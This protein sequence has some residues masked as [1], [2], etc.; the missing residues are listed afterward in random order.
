LEQTAKEQTPIL[1]NLTSMTQQTLDNTKIFTESL[2]NITE[3]EGI[4]RA[5]QKMGDSSILIKSLGPMAKGLD[6]VLPKVGRRISKESSIENVQSSRSSTQDPNYSAYSSPPSSVTEENTSTR[7]SADSSK[8]PFYDRF[9]PNHSTRKPSAK[10]SQADG[11]FSDISSIVSVADSMEPEES[12]LLSDYSS[13]RS[14]SS[15]RGFPK[16]LWQ[17]PVKFDRSPKPLSKLPTDPL[18]LTPPS[19][20][21]PS[22]MLSRR[23]TLMHDRGNTDEVSSHPSDELWLREQQS[24]RRSASQ[25]LVEHSS[26]RKQSEGNPKRVPPKKP[27]KPPGLQAISVNQELGGASEHHGKAK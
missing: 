23:K 24:A 18:H 6:R 27:S 21:A 3:N 5:A 14:N 25:P 2:A 15:S 7:P 10:D 13:P 22:P 26:H 9:F 17:L 4:L 19:T 12:T 16:L 1:Q 8:K 11:S 20:Q